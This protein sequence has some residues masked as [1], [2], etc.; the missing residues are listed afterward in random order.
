MWD[1]FPFLMSIR[2]LEIVQNEH[3]DESLN[4]CADFFRT[5]YRIFEIILLNII[6]S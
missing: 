5:T 4:L 6:K 2:V 1:K 3:F